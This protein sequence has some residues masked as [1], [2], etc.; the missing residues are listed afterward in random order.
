MNRE[1]HVRF[2]ESAGV[3]FPGA[4]QQYKPPKLGAPGCID[5][6]SAHFALNSVARCITSLRD[7]KTSLR[8]GGGLGSSN[9]AAHHA[10]KRQTLNYRHSSLP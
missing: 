10:G 1:I 6:C 2:W 3:R 9:S 4:T 5:S 8:V 7:A